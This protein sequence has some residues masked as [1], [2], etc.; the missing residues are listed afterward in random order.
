MTTPAT[1]RIRF[2]AVLTGFVLALWICAWTPVNNIYHQGTPLAGGHFPLAPFGVLIFLVVGSA[3]LRKVTR[4]YELFSGHELLIIWA[5]TT[6]ASGVAYTGLAR[7]L[8][9]NLTAPFQ[10]ATVENRWEETLQPLLPSMMFP[11][12]RQAIRLL[13]DGLQ[14][15]RQMDWIEVVRQVPWQAWM[16]PL[17]FW[18]VFVLSAYAVMICLISLT[19]RQW[20]VYERMNLP[21]LQV[22]LA[23]EEAYRER[24]LSAFWTNPFLVAGMAIP[25]FLHTIN[26]L[27]SLF[28][29]VPSIPTLIL[30]GSYFSPGGLFSAFTKLKIAIYP[31]FIGFAF[32]T[33]KQISLS[34]WFFFVA[35]GLVIG[36]LEF[37]GYRIP[38]SALGVTFGPTLARP[39]ETQM[40]GAYGVFF[41]FLLWLA[42]DHL[43]NVI[44]EAFGLRRPDPDIHEWIPSRAAFWGLV[45]GC[46]ILY[47]ACLY[48]GMSPISAFL[49]LTAAFMVM[50]V[51]T[52][53][54]CQGGIAYF[55]LTAA[56]TDGIL[57]FTGMRFL[58][59]IDGL[60]AAVSQKVLFLD[61]RE[62]LMPS[63]V[64]ARRVS[65]FRSPQRLWT[66]AMSVTLIGAVVVS[67]VAMLALCYRYGARSLELEWAT[68]TTVNLYE[69]VQKLIQTAV[70]P[71]A[72][73]VKVFSVAGAL[74]MLVLVVC[75]HRFYW[76]PIHPIGYLT[77]YSSAMRILWFS[78]FCGWLFNAVCMRYGGIG[79]FR[80]LRLFFIG[81]VIGDFLMGGLWALVGLGWDT[82]Y[83]V[84]PD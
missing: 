2:H 5:L 15:G 52:R 29:S 13:Y 27:S 33:A 44:L 50:M 18:G 14:H 35:G 25:V 45:L 20:L 75:Y 16:G 1:T 57:A 37:F 32:L 67:L 26:G 71:H 8:F 58:G 61:L 49:F 39:E 17:T 69:D 70:H 68:R 76:W 31:A 77:A 63:L 9:I 6:L 82:T 3:L 66:V 59:G 65:G 81:L 22:P 28:P 10:F 24:R 74:V 30:A 38:E 64:H 53:V 84:M 21:L 7:T 54:I 51:A 48:A 46:I 60:L 62:S 34:F 80:K 40:I 43:K 47:G 12:D 83:R 4:G 78:F 42:R 23:I 55:T 19:S 56:P 73:W 72:A 36:G 79:V 11:Q 41:L